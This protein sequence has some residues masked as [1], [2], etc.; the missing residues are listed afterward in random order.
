MGMAELEGGFVS[1]QCGELG[2][3]A[4]QSK[5]ERVRRE[6]LRPSLGPALS[7]AAD[8]FPGH[9]SPSQS[10]APSARSSA[11]LVNRR[12]S[13]DMLDGDSAQGYT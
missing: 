10:P 11:F 2:G 8:S 4:F 1:V 12:L 13:P 6:I 3:V 7:D 9:P 5:N